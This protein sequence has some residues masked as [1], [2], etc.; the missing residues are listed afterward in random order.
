MEA[1]KII[2]RKTAIKYVQTMNQNCSQNR[3]VC[4]YNILLEL[5]SMQ[6]IKSYTVK[7][8]PNKKAV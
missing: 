6:L 2:L 3:R 7:K 1:K 5:N 4:I 8:L